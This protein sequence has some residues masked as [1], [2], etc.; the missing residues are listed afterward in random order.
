M[1]LGYTTTGRAFLPLSPPTITQSIFVRFKQIE[2]QEKQIKLLMK[3]AE[4]QGVDR[5]EIYETVG[6]L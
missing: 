6:A 3:I 4:K 2:N 5:N 1:G